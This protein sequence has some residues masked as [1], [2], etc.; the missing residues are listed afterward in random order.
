[1]KM[2]ANNNTNSNWLTVDRKGFAQLIEHRNKGWIL[3]ELIQ[4]AWDQDVKKVKV[5]IESMSGKPSS[6]RVTVTDDD[7]NGWSDITH[8]YTMFAPSAKKSDTQKRGRFNLGEK[9]VLALADWAQIRTVKSA[10]RFDQSG[11]SDLGEQERLERG[12]EFQAIFQFTETDIIDIE[13]TL[14]SMICPSDIITVWSIVGPHCVAQCVME[15]RGCV[16]TFSTPLPTLIEGDGGKMKA[17]V[18]KTAV[19]LYEPKEGERAT[20]YEM[21]IPVVELGDDDKWHIDINQK[22]PLNMDRDNVTPGYLKAV[23]VAVL[24]HAHHLLTEGEA[25][26]TWVTAA[27]EDSRCSEGATETVMSKRFGDKRV[28]YDPSDKEANN[29]AMAKGYTVVHGGA[30]TKGQWQ[31]LKE[32]GS[33]K[34]AGKVTPSSKVKSGGDKDNT[35][36]FDDWTEDMINTVRL[37]G[38]MADALLPFT[39]LR[40]N[41]V[42]DKANMRSRAWYGNRAITF[43]LQSCGHKFFSPEN[44]QGQIDLIIHEFGH[45]YSSNHL[46]EEYYHGLTMLGAKLAMELSKDGSDL[47]SHIRKT[48]RVG[49]MS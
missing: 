30:L 7:P 17:T 39:G 27:S 33:L 24:N 9:M 5:Q 44:L 14:R 46:S 22:V 26:T 31:N 45:E 10:I 36:R 15:Q 20:I 47:R 13:A 43:N 3:C 28:A 37:T 32:S 29:I 41:I 40:I 34:P 2:N 25:K 18:R 21:G 23:R 19:A 48:E 11:M 35:V 6:Y 16:E 49:V 12:S 1:M 42:L 4:N 8:A 38:L